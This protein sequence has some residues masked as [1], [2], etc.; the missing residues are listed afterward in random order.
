VG[1]HSCLRSSPNRSFKKFS[2]GRDC[3]RMNFGGYSLPHLS[4]AWRTEYEQ[5][6]CART[7]S[8]VAPYSRNVCA[9]QY[10]SRTYANTPHHTVVEQK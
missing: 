5:L 1:A 10:E 2:L 8:N 9:E 3:G 4:S 7:S 6:G